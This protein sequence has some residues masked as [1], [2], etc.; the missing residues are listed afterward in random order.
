MKPIYSPLKVFHCREH[1]GAL[2]SGHVVPPVHIRLKPVNACNHNC[3][4]CA[5]RSDKLDLQLGSMMNTRDSIPGDKLD[6]IVRDIV[7]MGVKAVTFSGGG[8]PLIHP[9]IPAA[10]E[11]L[12][13]G[14]VKVATLTN[15]ALLQ[16]PAAEQFSRHG[17][18]VRVSI[19]AWD[20]PSYAKARGVSDKEYDKVMGNIRRFAAAGSRCF[21]GASFIVTRENAA[22]VADFC[23]QAKAAGVRNVKLSACVVAN[24]SAEN[25]A[26][27]APLADLLRTQIEACRRLEDAAFT[28]TDHYHRMDERFEK[29]YHRCPTLM[30]LTV[31]GADCKVYTCQDKA[32]TDGGLLGSIRDRSFKDFWFSEENARRMADVDP[33]RDCRHH[34]VAHAKN[35]LL[36]DYLSLDPEHRDF[37]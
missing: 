9:R 15:G 33:C 7:A 3:W 4:Y 16:G 12:A 30:F 27:H 2:I 6:E 1:L 24:T 25:N 13:Q 10:V 11:M 23:R 22:H 5:Y 34:C 29:A 37:V 31:I 35:V 18:W 28:V 36:D 14:G 20:G 8:E 26:Y 32:Y 19:D 21:I 17:T